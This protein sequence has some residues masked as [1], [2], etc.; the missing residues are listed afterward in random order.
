MAK[1]RRSN[2][3]R[4]DRTDEALLTLAETLFAEFFADPDTEE[5][6]D[7]LTRAERGG[8]VTIGSMELPDGGAARLDMRP[9][10]DEFTL[11]VTHARFNATIEARYSPSSE[12]MT[13]ARVAEV[14][15]DRKQ[16]RKLAD[17]WF[18]EINALDDDD[19]ELGSL[20]TTLLSD[21]VSPFEGDDPGEPPPP[22]AEDAAMVRHLARTLAREM[23][24][25]NPDLMSHGG[26]LEALERAPQ[27]LWPILDGMIEACTAEAPDDT[28]V[29]A[30]RFLLESQLTLIRYRIDRGW[31]WATRMSD[32][33]QRKLEEIGHEGRL[34]PEYVAMMIAALGEAGI[35]V[36]PETREVLA[37][38]A[39][40]SAQ[41]SKPAGELQSLLRGLMDQLAAAASTPFQVADGLGDATRVMPT[42]LRCFM[43]HEFALSEH[44][45]LRDTVP[46]MLLA[47]EQEVRRAA[48][49]ALEQIAEP[50]TLSPESLRRMIA[51]RNWVPEADRAPIDRAIR[52]A[53]MKGV[54]CALWPTA[55][56]LVVTA[57]VIDGSGAQSILLTSRTG[58]KGILGG[59][60]I[61]L[62]KGIVDSWCQV[63]TPRREIRETLAALSETGS[64]CEVDPGYFGGAIQNS[65]AAGV[66]A[67][68]PPGPALL[69]VAELAGGADWRDRRLD[70]PAEAERLF[71]ALPPAERSPSAIEASLNRSGHWLN[72]DFAA[73][74]FLDDAES[75]AIV[76]R[77]SRRDRKSPADRLLTEI[78]PKRRVEWAERCLLMALRARAAKDA[79]D[80]ALTNDFVILT[81]ALAGDRPLRDIPLMVAIAETTVTV[82]R[83]SHW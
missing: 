40:Q 45:L 56:D 35:A 7:R 5:E 36:R 74:W 29:E 83:L 21:E 70:V 19:D 2:Q 25:K 6:Y 43:A 69:Q 64:A 55:M 41:G 60:L 68:E 32:D 65:I 18:E 72:Q 4:A 23:K 27:S 67:G 54:K 80:K 75:R 39:G 1:P 3:Q 79:S 53:R 44:A 62:G 16:A 9:G 12:V 57:S 31:D 14:E 10:S 78:L 33:Y 47:E 58:R 24:R 66:A 15:G 61:R 46:L 26:D 17:K 51:I 76:T 71:E 30:W 11:T 13:E 28:I 22:S 8:M 42:E 37:A 50:G 73:S 52:K 34:A 38:I 77:T 48:A 20:L 82:A 81:H 49:A 59:V 63:D